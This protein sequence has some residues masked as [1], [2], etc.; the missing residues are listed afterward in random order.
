MARFSVTNTNDS[1]AGS[2][3]QEILDANALSGKDIINFGGLFNDGLAHTI[4]LTGSS[5]SIT[6]DITILGRNPNLLTISDNSASRVFDI[7]SGATATINGL[8][9]TNSYNAVEGG[10]GISNKGVLTLNN[11]I[12]TGNTAYQGGGIS[13]RGSM[14]LNHS[15]IFQ[16]TASN[17]GGGIFNSGTMT[18]NHSTISD[19]TVKVSGSGDFF[20]GEGGGIF[21]SGS[22]TVNH[23]SVS[24]NTAVNGGGLYMFDTGNLSVNNSSITDNLA[25]IRGGGIY[26]NGDG[27]LAGTITVNNSIISRNSALKGDG[28]GIYDSIPGPGYYDTTGAIIYYPG[29]N[30]KIITLTNSIITD[31]SA[32]KNG[33]GIYNYDS[34]LFPG[35]HTS[36]TISLSNCIITGNLAGADGGGI[37]NLGI[38]T[39]SKSIIHGNTAKSGGGGIYNGGFSYLGDKAPDTISYGNLTVIKSLISDNSASTG[40]G[41]YNYGTLSVS[42]SSISD[43]SAINYGGGIYNSSFNEFRRYNTFGIVNLS[44]S[45]INDNQA[46]TAGGG[47]YNDPDQDFGTT[48]RVFPGSYVTYDGLGIVTVSDSMISG[49]QAHFGAGIYNNAT[50]TVGNSIIKHNKAF[51]IELSSGSYESGD[52]GGIYN[53]STYYATAKLNDSIIA[54]NFDTCQED[55]NNRIQP[56]DIAGNF[57]NNGYNWIGIN[58]A[59]T[60]TGDAA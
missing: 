57:I 45:S 24:D 14:T 20:S 49:N 8:T 47:I 11:S 26:L 13:N 41:I 30:P 2:L 40:G 55:S 38:L 39:L 17:N 1:G 58:T 51:G 35:N 6:D 19:N 50:L 46:G 7:T 59:T 34:S 33:G 23:S 18:L 10:G 4:S 21:N 12:I 25:S 44:H 31:N 52:G 37:Y 42:Y 32:G 16:N 29:F 15:T 28:G 27:P 53:N 5:L 48:K 60:T 54:C 22:L 9:I 56:D 36:S 43:N 3:R